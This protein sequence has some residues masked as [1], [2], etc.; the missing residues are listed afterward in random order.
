MLSFS[1]QLLETVALFRD[2]GVLK[3]NLDALKRLVSRLSAPEVDPERSRDGSRSVWKGFLWENIPAKDVVDFLNA[4]RTHPEA[5]RVNSALLAEFIQSMV[6]AGELTRWTIALVGGGQGSDLEVSPG[7]SVTML[8]RTSESNTDYRY[9]IGRLMS[10]RDEAIDLD[11]AGWRAA[12]TATKQAWHADPA[13]L[14]TSKEPEIPSGTAVRKVRGFGA[15]GVP[16]HPD[17]GVLVLYALDPAKAN[18]KFS[19]DTPAIVAFGISFPGS[20]SGLKV[21]YKVNN[22]LWE[23]EYGP[24]D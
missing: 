20:N 3:A 18:A 22:V 6:S 17:R 5:Y 13:R 16:A 9:S 2:V 12:L 19:L 24:A 1:G 21:E 4:Y 14:K 8:Q 15:E 23:Q 10:P 11:D 7:L